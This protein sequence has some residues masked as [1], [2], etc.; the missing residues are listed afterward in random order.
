MLINLLKLLKF[1]WTHPINRNS[2]FKAIFRVIRFQISSRILNVP[3][4]VPFVNDTF[5]F[6]KKGMT[7]A[8]GNLYCG[9]SEYSDMG[10]VLHTLQPGDLFEDVEDNI[11]YTE[12]VGSSYG[13]I[14]ILIG[15]AIL[16]IVFYIY[17][18]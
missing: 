12:N 4:L 16:S 13:W 9:L 7:G 18:V 15:L 5:L 11:N 17:V 14:L 1:V 8:T 10:F 3:F 6:T 2:R